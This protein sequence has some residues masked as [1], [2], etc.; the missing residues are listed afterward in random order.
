MKNLFTSLFIVAA[1]AVTAHAAVTVDFTEVDYPTYGS[2]VNLTNQLADDGV[3]FSNVYRYIDNRDPWLE[4]DPDG[5]G[6]WYYGD[7][8]FGIANGV[9]EGQLIEVTMGTVYFT[10]PVSKV[11]IDWWDIY[12]GQIHIIA[13][14]SDDNV[15]DTFDGPTTSTNDLG[16]ETLWG[17]NVISY[18]TFNN[19]GG[20]V[21]IANM[22]FSPIPA[23]GAVLLGGIGVVLVGWLRRRRIL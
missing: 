13:Y 17:S 7:Y 21:Q 23:P 3:T 14:D 2:I 20:L 8:G 19:S 12:T 1:L 15:V 5:G 9:L 10:T 22:T 16:T 11:T 4:L 6:T 18:L